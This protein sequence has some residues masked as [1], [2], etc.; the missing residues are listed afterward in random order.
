MF[1]NKNLVAVFGRKHRSGIKTHTEGGDV[2]SELLCRWGEFT[3]LA[4]FTKLVIG[5]IAAVAIGIPEVKPWLGGAVQFVR[6]CIVS[7]LVAPIVRKPKL[8]SSW[9]P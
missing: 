4:L 2:W 9:M 3:T 5:N 8:F 7:G 1:G 6:R